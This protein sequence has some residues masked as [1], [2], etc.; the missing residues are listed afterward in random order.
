MRKIE[1]E[2]VRAIE[3]GKNKSI[4]NTRI[5]HDRIIRNGAEII[6][7]SLFL[8]NNRI[9]CGDRFNPTPTRVNLRGWGTRTTASR[10]RALGVALYKKRGERFIGD[11]AIAD[12][13]WFNVA[14][15]F[16]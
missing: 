11:N 6:E 16:N 10:I 4:G 9:A 12:S 7:W 1:Q 2:I 13:G 3:R 15:R 8:H 5:E 14:P